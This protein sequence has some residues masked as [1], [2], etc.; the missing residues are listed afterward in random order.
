MKHGSADATGPS[1][2][3]IGTANSEGLSDKFID[4][5]WS[6]SENGKSYDLVSWRFTMSH[7]QY[8]NGIKIPG[9]S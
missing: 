9:T 8:G 2:I 1:Y 5:P 4:A 6:V 7:T 3:V